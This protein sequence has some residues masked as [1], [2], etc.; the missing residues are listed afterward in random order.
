MKQKMLLNKIL[1]VNSFRKYYQRIS[2]KCLDLFFS[3]LN[4]LFILLISFLIFTILLVFFKQNFV[5]IYYALAKSSILTIL[6]IK[7]SLRW[8]TPLLFTGIAV[9]IAFKGGVFNIGVEG[10]FYL[11]AFAATWACITFPYLNRYLIIPFAF[12]SAILVGIIW[13]FIPL[14]LKEKFKTN[15]VITCLMLNYIAILFTEWLVRYPYA[16]P[17]TAG[18]TVATVNIPNSAHLTSLIRGSQVTSGLIIGFFIC[19]LIWFILSKT[20]L[21]FEIKQVGMNPIFSQYIGITPL[22]IRFISM[23]LSGAFAGLGGAIEILGVQWRFITK[24]T[25]GLGF[26]GIVVSL[27]ANNNPIG[28]IFS[29]FFIGALKSGSFG[30]ERTIG[31]SRALVTVLQG[32]VIALI[33]IEKMYNYK[34]KRER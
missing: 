32:I 9:A 3:L 1:K 21:G 7:T 11:G 31:A 20:K 4:R 25:V 13:S 17:G 12:L 5:K 24:F 19:I 26:D 34:R 30:I 22:K 14:F 29:S 10:Q 6:G 15:E 2:I 18:E 27:L 33:T 23:L 16:A 8:M 28:V